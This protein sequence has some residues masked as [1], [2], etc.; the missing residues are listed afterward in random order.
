MAEKKK[1]NKKWLIAIAI[2]V[3]IAV[4]VVLVIV[5]LPKNTSKAITQVK[6]QS[7]K[8]YL[9]DN[10][11]KEMFDSFQRK[12]NV[13][14]TDYNEEVASAK[15][16]AIVIQ[17][18]LD[19]Y[20]DYVIYAT[21][22]K[23][24]QNNYNVIMDGFKDANL[25][26]KEMNAIAHEVYNKVDNST[27]F[28]KG[29]WLDFKT[30]YV[31][32]VKS[33]AKAFRGLNNVFVSCVPHGVINNDFTVKVLATVDNYLTVINKGF[34]SRA[35]IVNYASDFVKNYLNAD[36]LSKYKFS[37]NLQKKL[38]SINEFDQ[39]YGKTIQDLIESV[40]KN[41]FTIKVIEADKNGQILTDSQLFLIG[42][43]SA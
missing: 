16:I 36:L 30:V 3:L 20:N 14:A 10:E 26:Q 40:D 12:I 42:G 21:N 23:V 31:K 4:V 28:T 37:E 33:Y 8:V 1:I 7:E 11:E 6:A 15:K 43:L 19:F 35:K 34:D 9:K 41:G 18:V 27:T 5:L 17:E 25:Y 13:S 24:F 29:A 32:Y 38:T 22:T 39:V 2:L